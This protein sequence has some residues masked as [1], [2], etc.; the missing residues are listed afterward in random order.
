M[1]FSQWM[2]KKKKN[3]AFNS[4]MDELFLFFENKLRVF[5]EKLVAH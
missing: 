4:G 5:K 3:A 1:S 2:I